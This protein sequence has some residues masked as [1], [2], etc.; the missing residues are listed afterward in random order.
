MGWKKWLWTLDKCPKGEGKFFKEEI[1]FLDMS[2]T[3]V[4]VWNWIV[5]LQFCEQLVTPFDK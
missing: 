3:L 1:F 4:Y 2:T 5:I